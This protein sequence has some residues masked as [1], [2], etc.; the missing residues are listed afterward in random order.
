[1]KNYVMPLSN[2]EKQRRFKERLKLDPEKYNKYKKKKR[3]SYH[4][5]KRLVYWYCSSDDN[6]PLSVLKNLALEDQ[7]NRDS[8]I[9]ISHLCQPRDKPTYGIIY[10]SEDEQESC[11]SV[12][13][14]SGQ[15]QRVAY[16]QGDY[17]LVNV[18]NMKGK[19]Y[20]YVC[21]IDELDDDGEIRVTFLRRVNNAKT[22]RL[23][24][25][26]VAYIKH[27][28]IIKKLPRPKRGQYHF[29]FTDNIDIFEM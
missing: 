18:Q 6:E 1:M 11:S 3:E 17:L 8:E 28:D 16:S 13:T 20:R 2:K 10:D 15:E 19:L 24:K 4:A 26:D 23:D 22:F 9:E 29:Q 25:N 27:E 7:Q 12:P 14:G 21:V 5:T